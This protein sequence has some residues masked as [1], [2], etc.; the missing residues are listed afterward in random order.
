VDLSNRSEPD[1]DAPRGIGIGPGR[2][3]NAN[4][5]SPG[6]SNGNGGLSGGPPPGQSYRI[7]DPVGVVAPAA[8][9]FDGLGGLGGLGGLIFHFLF[10]A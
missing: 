1:D 6:G 8:G 7:V 5:G 2:N 9:L 3:G 10:G 4:G